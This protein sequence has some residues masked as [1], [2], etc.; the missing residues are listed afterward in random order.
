M[1]GQVTPAVAR[2][3]L[4]D[5]A[6]AVARALPLRVAVFVEEQGVPADIE[7]DQWDAR[8]L[9]ALACDASGQVLGTGRLLPDGH[10]GRMAVARDARGRGVGSALLRALL[11]EAAR[12]GHSQALQHA[13]RDAVAFY[14]AHGFEISGAEFLEAGIV[15]LPMA[16]RLPG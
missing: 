2:I 1:G 14:A 12:R 15:H 13:Q 16:R 4:L 9:H 3:E 6:Q 5:W 7:H 11:D 8:S 10:I